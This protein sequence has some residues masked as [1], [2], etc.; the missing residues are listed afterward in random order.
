MKYI[1]Y[2][3]T[4]IINL[5]IYVGVHQTENPDIFDG[6]LGNGLNRNKPSCL[7]H[8]K[9]PFHYA[10]KKYGFD[11]FKRETIKVFDT[12]EEALYLEGLI[13]DE[14]FIRREDTY[15]VAL[16]GGLPPRK[17]IKVYQYDL[18]GN[19]IK[20][21]NSYQE[22][23]IYY[24]PTKN[25]SAGASIYRAVTYKTKSF[26]FLWSNKKYSSLNIDDFNNKTQNIMVYI[27][28]L[29]YNY[30]KSFNSIMDCCRE[31]NICLEQARRSIRLQ[32]KAKGF[33]ISD[34]LYDKLPKI[35][36]EKLVGDIHQ[37]DLEGNYIK[38]Y[39]SISEAQK[40][41]GITLKNLNQYI[42]NTGYYKGFQWRRGDF[43][44]S[45]PKYKVK[46]TPKKVGQY[47]MDGV[48]VKIFNTVREARKEYPNVSKVLSG[49]ANHC[50]NYTFKYID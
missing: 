8:P 6:Y 15:N 18:N 34:I 10:V 26:N 13:V 14:D 11:S 22:A 28:D 5:H 43:L 48:L 50:H 49:T 7:N 30:I 33:Y 38:S 16:G 36:Q 47:T 44:E 37:Y 3:T 9:E 17:D 32:Y 12:L 45:I 27:Y 4:N 19:Y 39:S 24:S 23:G 1:V 42:K 29:N 2:L 21:W 31:L 35:K 46:S 41:T 40:E 25:I 20:E